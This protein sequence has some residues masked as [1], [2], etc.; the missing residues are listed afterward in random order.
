MVTL[1]SR[2]ISNDVTPQLAK[3]LL[4]G[5]SGVIVNWLVFTMLR[6]YLNVSTMS[7]TI[8][9]HIVLISYIFPLQ[10][11]CTFRSN[12]NTF[13][14]LIKF[15]INTLG[16]LS[17]DFLLAWVFIDFLNILPAIGKACGL[18]FLTPLSFLFQKYW[19]FYEQI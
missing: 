11:Y 17:L 4:I 6:Q 5:A 10:K 3:H 2:C 16:Y 8:I 9:V 18:T 19:V 14:A 1:I 15:T 7:A 13:S 12:C